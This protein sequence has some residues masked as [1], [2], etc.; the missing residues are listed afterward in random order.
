VSSPQE[1]D[2]VGKNLDIWAEDNKGG[3]KAKKVRKG[4]KAF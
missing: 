4:R 2:S 1:D 3:N